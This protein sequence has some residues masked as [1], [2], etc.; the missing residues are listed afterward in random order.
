MS[1]EKLIEHTGNVVNIIK[2]KSLSRKEK[3]KKFLEE[4]VVIVIAISL[5]LLFHNWNDARHEKKIARE[6]LTGVK[7]D[8]TN[9]ANS[10]EN[11]IKDFQPTIDYYDTV[12]QQI[13]SKKINSGYIDSLSDY[14]INTSYLVYD[15]GR[16]QG[17]K[18]SGYLRLI[19]NQELLRQLVN[20]Y[21]V[22][23]PFERDADL[24]VFRTREADYNLYIGTKAVIGPNGPVISSLLN[25]PAAR[26]QIYRYVNYFEER[27]R[28]KIQLV[29]RMREMVA[30]IDKELNG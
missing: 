24:N 29:K 28:H 1:E 6:F 7:D 21:S 12:W 16:F 25:D 10:V 23:L 22:Y 15:D 14:L 2:N 11:S 26:Y 17:F 27:K 9:G 3:I 18:S 19:E 5:T 4:I 30:S 8:L 20:L 13:S